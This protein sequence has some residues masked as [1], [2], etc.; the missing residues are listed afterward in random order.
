MEVL[1]R[2]LSEMP[3]GEKRDELMKL[4]AARMRRNLET[5]N[6]DSLNDE[7]IQNDIQRYMDEFK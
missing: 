2:E 4:A 5:W 3:E 7:K 1:L 6:K